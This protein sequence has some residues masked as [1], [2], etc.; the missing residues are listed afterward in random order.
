MSSLNFSYKGKPLEFAVFISHLAQLEKEVSDILPTNTPTN[1]VFVA[2]SFIYDGRFKEEYIVGGPSNLPDSF[3]SGWTS[4][5][6]NPVL[7]ETQTAI[8]PFCS[9]PS[10]TRRIRDNRKTETFRR[11]SNACRKGSPF[12][13]DYQEGLFSRKPSTH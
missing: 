3:E 7:E 8:R 10:K 1:I 5:M 11:M 12:S 2:I 9:S 4:M 13:K 6:H